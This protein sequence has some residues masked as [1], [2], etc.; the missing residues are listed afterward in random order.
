MSQWVGWEYL[1]LAQQDEVLR[2]IIEFADRLIAARAKS[3][4]SGDEADLSALTGT[5]VDSEMAE[6]FQHLVGP[7]IYDVQKKGLAIN[8][9]RAVM[10]NDPSIYKVF[11][12]K[13][14]VKAN[15]KKEAEQKKRPKKEGDGTQSAKTGAAIGTDGDDKTQTTVTCMLCRKANFSRPKKSRG[16]VG[17]PALWSGCD[18]C[19]KTMCCAALEC[20]THLA[21]HVKYCTIK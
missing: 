21:T 15:R 9:W 3:S 8:R 14:L 1:T 18:R 2:L 19:K 20:Q 12:Q 11:A 5:P 17:L 13:E 6:V 4:S 7:L 16:L 10:I